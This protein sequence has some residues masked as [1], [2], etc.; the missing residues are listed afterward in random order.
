M[1]LSLSLP[2]TA[3]VLSRCLTGREC[4]LACRLANGCVQ[5]MQILDPIDSSLSSMCSLHFSHPL[6]KH[7]PLS[8][9][10]FI[11]TTL[12]YG[13]GPAGCP[14]WSPLHVVTPLYDNIERR[15]IIRTCNI[16][17]GGIRWRPAR[18]SPCVDLSIGWE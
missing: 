15:C 18:T 6:K 1:H 13:G 3:C 4:A 9:S 12:D 5:G 16:I 2:P 11:P 7:L 8:V 17:R 10:L 14:A